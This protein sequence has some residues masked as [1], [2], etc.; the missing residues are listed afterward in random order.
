MEANEKDIH[1]GLAYRQLDLV[2]RSAKAVAGDG[3][4]MTHDGI[5]MRVLRSAIDI[6]YPDGFGVIWDAAQILVPETERTVLSDFFCFVADRKAD[7]IW[8][9]IYKSANDRVHD[10]MTFA[11]VTRCYQHAVDEVKRSSDYTETAQRSV[12]L[13]ASKGVDVFEFACKEFLHLC[14]QE[15]FFKAAKKAIEVKQENNLRVLLDCGVSAKDSRLMQ[16]AALS[17]HQPT[18]ELL[19]EKGCDKEEARTHL[20]YMLRTNMGLGA[21]KAFCDAFGLEEPTAG[22][23]YSLRDDDILLESVLLGDGITLRTVFNFTNAQ[24]TVMVEGSKTPQSPTVVSF[25]KVP[26]SGLKA[27]WERLKL[28]GGGQHCKSPVFT[29]GLDLTMPARPAAVKVGG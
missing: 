21:I 23:R 15:T 13:A 14:D 7:D 3:G 19:A 10:I 1:H 4:S 25:E 20:P 17:G 28:L 29:T 8:S 24:Q 18:L 11:M 27:A 2:R 9:I 22:G 12:M 5:F 26:H 6:K 16:A